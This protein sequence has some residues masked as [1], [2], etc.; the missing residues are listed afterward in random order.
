[1][2]K[3]SALVNNQSKLYLPDISPQKK[4]YL[5]HVPVITPHQM[6]YHPTTCQTDKI[7]FCILYKWHP[8]LHMQAQAHMYITGIIYC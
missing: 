8:L 1:M 4:L 2:K 5:P 3:T 6:M 7:M